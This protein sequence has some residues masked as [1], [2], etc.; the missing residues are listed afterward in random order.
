MLRTRQIVHGW[1]PQQSNLGLKPWKVPGEWLA[2]KSK[3]KPVNTSSNVSKEIRCSHG[4]N[5]LTA[6]GK[7]KEAKLLK[8]PLSL[9][10]I[11][12]L[13]FVCTIDNYTPMIIMIFIINHY[14][15]ISKM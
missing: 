4:V 9:K 14:I 10:S 13:H 8:V 11:N 15:N 2:L 1:I 6:K 3:W 7:S 12:N 5:Q